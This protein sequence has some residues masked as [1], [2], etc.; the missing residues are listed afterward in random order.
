MLGL[1]RTTGQMVSHKR[2]FAR[3]LGTFA[4]FLLAT[5]LHPIAARAQVAPTGDHHGARASD[6]GFTR[7]VNS[8]GGFGAS[9]PLDLPS[10]RGN[11]PLPLHVSYGG[12]RFGAAGVGWDVPLSFIRRDRTVAHRRPAGSPG[13]GPQAREQL[14]LTLDG[15]G[16]DLVRNAAST[17]WLARRDGAQLEVR[18][19]GGGVLET[20]DGNGLKYSFSSGGGSVGLP[21]GGNL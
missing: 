8:S 20:Y 19:T 9:V 3:S 10:V 17:A 12:Y 1:T 16:T 5:L 14:S 2:F 15:Q 4:G 11:L 7:A 6:T 18:G 21:D 13:V